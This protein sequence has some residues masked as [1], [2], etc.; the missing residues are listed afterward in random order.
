MSILPAE[1]VYE[2]GARLALALDRWCGAPEAHDHEVLL[3]AI[4]PVLDVGCGPGRHLLALALA[5]IPALGI[6]VAPSAVRL[7]RQRGACVLERSVFE[8]IPAS[9]RW[10]SALLL[11]GNAGIGG[12]PEALLVRV[13]ALLRPGGRILME[14]EPPGVDGGRMRA[15]VHRGGDASSW[16]AW[17]R[18]G[19]DDVAGLAQSCALGL[20]EVWH[21][22]PRWFVMLERPPW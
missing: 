13:R 15:R 18:V 16:F 20:L 22:G 11:D 1:L 10:G 19:A 9:G 3:R 5:G 8:R 2:D 6:D 14:V 21:Q 7:A 4:P 12:D 17:A